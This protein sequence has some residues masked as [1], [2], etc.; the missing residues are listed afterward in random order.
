MTVLWE[1]GA[2]ELGDLKRRVRGQMEE[3]C[4]LNKKVR[5]AER[6]KEQ[7]EREQQRLHEEL[8]FSR[9]QVRMKPHLS[10]GAH[11]WLSGS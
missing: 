7:R 1:G 4:Q 5:G 9:Q 10:S 8:R 6:R 2:G 3:A 11:L